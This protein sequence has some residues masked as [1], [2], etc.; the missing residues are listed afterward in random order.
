MLM[1]LIM[2]AVSWSK[3]KVT[4]NF[5]NVSSRGWS[6][7]HLVQMATCYFRCGCG[8]IKMDII[9]VGHVALTLYHTILTF[10]DPEK[11]AT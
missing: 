9:P 3:V 1:I 2:F 5:N 10:K 4:V 7:C 11:D 8:P 6:H